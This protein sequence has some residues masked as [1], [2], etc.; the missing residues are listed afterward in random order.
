[1]ICSRLVTPGGGVS[2]ARSFILLLNEKTNWTLVSD[3]RR[4]RWMSLTNSLMSLSSTNIA[5]VILLKVLLR[6]SPSF[7]KTI[8]GLKRR[9]YYKDCG[10]E[11]RLRKITFWTQFSWLL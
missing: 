3:W 2:F 6:E 8:G 11:L 1:M 5:P 4:A 9:G 7:S 10:G